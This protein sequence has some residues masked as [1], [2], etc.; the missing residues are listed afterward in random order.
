[1]LRRVR[2]ELQCGWVWGWCPWIQTWPPLLLLFLCQLILHLFSFQ[3]VNDSSFL[4]SSESS[5][6]WFIRWT[7][8]I[9]TNKIMAQN[10]LRLGKC[11]GAAE[12]WPKHIQWG[13][14]QQKWLAFLCL[15]VWKAMTKAVIS[16]GSDAGVHCAVYKNEENQPTN[17]TI[18]VLFFFPISG[19]SDEWSSREVPPAALVRAMFAQSIHRPT[20][21][22][23]VYC[24]VNY[25]HS[26]LG[27]KPETPKD[28]RSNTPSTSKNGLICIYTGVT[29]IPTGTSDLP[30]KGN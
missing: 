28:F 17:K 9:L 24:N 12:L 27:N 26:N 21:P 3:V 20:K 18:P 25:P 14:L 5:K 4:H 1:M 11:G 13:F 23:P 19:F 8:N 15:R 30:D 22:E 16:P 6:D 2:S 7:S 29:E 10:L